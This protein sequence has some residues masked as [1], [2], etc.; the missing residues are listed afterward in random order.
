MAIAAQDRVPAPRVRVWD[1]LV[2]TFHWALAAAVVLAAA[3]GWLHRDSALHEAAGYAA[4]GLVVVRMTWGVVGT[5]YAR[6]A[7]FPARPARVL[8]YLGALARGRA[9]RYLGH[10]PAASAMA[11]A[12][13][14]T[15]LLVAV[16]GVV[17]AGVID[18]DGPL[19]FLYPRVGDATALALRHLHEW[20]VFALL[21]MV[22][23]HVLGVALSSVQHGENLVRAMVTGEKPLATPRHR[24]PPRD[25]AVAVAPA[26]DVRPGRVSAQ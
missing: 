21:A 5:H 1:R 12:L 22:V 4:A 16:S 17:T 9:A 23:L 14:A 6:F 26:S 11:L 15:A 2:R 18:L 24:E 8:R 10:S 3:T 25:S 20:V 13:L 7:N 19:A